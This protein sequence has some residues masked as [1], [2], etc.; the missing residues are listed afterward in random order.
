MFKW[1]C[2]LVVAVALAAFGWM[3]NDMRLAVKELSPKVEKLAGTAEEMAQKLD[4]HLPQILKETEQAGKT[5]N[6]SLPPLVKRS[7][8]LVGH[9]E[10]AVDSLAD[11]TDSFKQ[12]RDLMGIVHGAS[13]NKPLL[14]YGTSLLDFIGAQKATIGVKPSA[15]PSGPKDGA[16]PPALQRAMPASEW[17][18]AAR[19]DVAFLSLIAGSKEEMLHGLARTRSMA[20]LQIQLADQVPRLLGDWLHRESPQP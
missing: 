10:I 13:S 20:P 11:L 16:S 1:V 5:L 14:A 3:L 9:A 6:S 17:A 4:A 2:L 8:A 7:E 12:Y 19:K 18:R 15:P